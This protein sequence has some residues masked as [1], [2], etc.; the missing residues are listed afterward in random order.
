MSK[1]IVPGSSPTVP[2]VGLAVIVSAATAWLAVLLGAG[3]DAVLADRPPAAAWYLQVA[4]ALLAAGTGLVLIPV[5]IQRA[6]GR[7]Q[8]G[9]RARLLEHYLAIGPLALARGGHG[10][11]VNTAMDA[12]D[13]MVRY[14]AG[15]TGPALAAVITPFIVLGF[16]AVFLDASA[17]AI[18][19]ILLLLVPVIVLGFQRLFRSSS[20]AYRR[21]QGTLAAVFMDALRNLGMLKLNNAS[22]WMGTKVAAAAQNVR[23]QVMKLLARNQLVLLVID[24]TFA[25]LLLSTAALLAW[26]K[27][28]TGVLGVGGGLSLLA[29]SFLM[30]A[31][32]NYVGSFFYIGMTGRTAQE[33]ITQVLT[34]EPHPGMLTALKVDLRA[35]G[36]HLESVAA[37]YEDGADAI[38]GINLSFP[39]GSRT[40]VI[41][42]SGSGKST[43]L[44]L[45]SGQLET[46]AGLVHDT[47]QALGTATLRWNTA[48]VEQNS[49]LF[50]MSL[51]ENLALADPQATD[52]EMIG[53]LHRVGLGDWFEALEQGL[54]LP[55]GEGGAR[56]SGGQGQRLAIARAVLADR[57]VLLLDEP[58]SA[59]DVHTEAQVLQLLG[60][61]GQGRITITVTHRLSMLADYDRVVV[62][63]A[64]KVIQ[65]GR[66]QAVLAQD[67]YL[68]RAMA[69]YT[70]RSERIGGHR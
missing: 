62:M 12:V 59:L 33:R 1:V 5:V 8:A 48:V 52:Q 54:D 65:A 7:M 14:R 27:V 51:R 66:T 32:V 24:A 28:D 3:L 58:T 64:G 41:G 68:A 70:R 9:V 29:L 57:P 46:S 44:R 2:V 11:R 49:T 23:V 56:L 42:A 16:V 47:R 35:T 34:E 30:L 60:T 67:G 21:A 20:G 63:E 69:A 37:G 43:L 10:Q 53:L 36:L 19:G 50:A 13:R 25:L 45:L 31:P 15:F 18:L 6:S 39:A 40:A 61:V 55:L 22:G 4:L 17:A 38:S 26:W